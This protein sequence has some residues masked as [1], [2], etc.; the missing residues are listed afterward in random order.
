MFYN[1]KPRVFEKAK[2]LRE[3]MTASEQKLWQQ[4]KGKK[5]LNLRFRPQ[6]PVDK[7]IADFYCHPLKLIIEVDGGIHKSKDQKDYDLNREVELNFWGIK[8][9]RFTNDEVDQNMNLIITQIQSICLER[10]TELK[11]PLQ[12]I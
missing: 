3:N 9:I 10:R 1:A 6:H 2:I 11:S 5:M 4:L 8:V 12:G 7:F